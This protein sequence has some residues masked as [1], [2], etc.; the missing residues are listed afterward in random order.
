LALFFCI[1]LRN[2]FPQI[3][4]YLTSLPHKKGSKLSQ[5]APFIISHFLI[6]AK[7]DY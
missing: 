4:K 1:I 6:K 5:V 7:M 2:Y 3:E